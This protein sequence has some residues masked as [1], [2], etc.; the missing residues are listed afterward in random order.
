MRLNQLLNKTK[1]GETLTGKE[2]DILAK[3]LG[4]VDSVF[5]I[6]VKII[7][8]LVFLALGIYLAV[9]INNDVFEWILLFVLLGLGVFLILYKVNT[10]KIVKYLE[11]VKEFYI[12]RLCDYEG[13]E[14]MLVQHQ[15]MKNG[16]LQNNLAIFATDGYVFYLFDDFLKETI[17]LLPNKFKGPNNK[18][19]ALKVFNQE[20]VNKR[21]VCFE[22]KEIAYY[23]LNNPVIPD[24]KE[25]ES[26]GCIYRRYTFTI[27]D[28]FLSNYCLLVLNDGST[29]KLAPEAVTLLRKK[30]KKKERLG[31]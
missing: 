8:W 20:F 22:I 21:P 11:T 15:Y 9:I 6:V 2:I 14:S 18:R 7:I 5:V 31:E 27:K 16:Y 3:K 26:Y 10:S 13:F 17:Y 30:A 12:E 29:F 25:N 23:E 1:K 19:P 4:L 28:T 24:I